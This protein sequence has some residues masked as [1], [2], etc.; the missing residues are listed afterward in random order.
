M[1]KYLLSD[2]ESSATPTM[3]AVMNDLCRLA[4]SCATKLGFSSD[5]VRVDSASLYSALSRYL[6]D[7]FGYQ[8]ISNS[9]SQRFAHFASSCLPER[10]LELMKMKDEILEELHDCGIRISSDNPYLHKRMA[11][12]LYH[13]TISK[14]F[15][16]ALP[17][18]EDGGEKIAY[19]NAY[20]SIFIVN[21]ALAA[22]KQAL[23]VSEDFV[24]DLT[25][26]NLTRSSLEAVMR[27]VSR[28]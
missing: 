13:L 15:Y 26:H 19:F 3:K 14:P 9:I 2:W 11:F 4:S 25:Y 16:V 7:A 24:R 22:S 8:R 28:S 5:A 21:L 10:K 1:L 18:N 23:D 27:T 12:L 6:R 17:I 20:V